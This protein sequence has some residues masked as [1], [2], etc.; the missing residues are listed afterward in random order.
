MGVC[1]DK[2]EGKPRHLKTEENIVQKFGKAVQFKNTQFKKTAIIEAE[3]NQVV[4]TAEE[5]QLTSCPMK[6]DNALP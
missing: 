6:E 5:N 1:L 2:A 3:D 4:R